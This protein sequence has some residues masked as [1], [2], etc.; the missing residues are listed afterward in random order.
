MPGPLGSKPRPALPC[1]PMIG[2]CRRKITVTKAAAR[3]ASP[4]PGSRASRVHRTGGCSVGPARPS[5][6][7]PAAHAAPQSLAHALHVHSRPAEKRYPNAK[8]R[9]APQGGAGAPG[10]CSPGP[11]SAARRARASALLFS[12]ESI[13]SATCTSCSLLPFHR[14]LVVLTR[15]P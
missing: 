4:Q 6:P 3:R 10:K 9:D 8:P 2:T 5:A 1:I 7:A 12:V 13:G 15:G 11:G 14:G